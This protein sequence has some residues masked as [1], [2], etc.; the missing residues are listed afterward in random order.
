MIQVSA[1]DGDKGVSNTVSYSLLPGKPQIGLSTSR[2]LVK[3]AYQK[4]K[5]VFLDQN[6]SH[7][8]C[9]AIYVSI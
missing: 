5:F 4:K 1:V 2:P 7:S 6:I 9:M 3:S 8:M